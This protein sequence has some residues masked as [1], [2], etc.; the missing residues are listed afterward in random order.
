V[1]DLHDADARITA[2]MCGRTGSVL[3][4]RPDQAFS[5]CASPMSRCSLLANLADDKLALI[6]RFWH[7]P[8]YMLA[9]FAPVIML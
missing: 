8:S 9:A 4:Q 6:G 7:R 2:D 1:A 5:E 3:G